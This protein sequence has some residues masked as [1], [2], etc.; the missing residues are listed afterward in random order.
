MSVGN[1]AVLCVA[2]N[3]VYKSLEGVPDGWELVRIGVAKNGEWYI[4]GLG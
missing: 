4:D 2:R 3:S 1:V